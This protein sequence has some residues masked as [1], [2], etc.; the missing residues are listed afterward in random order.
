MAL[1]YPFTSHQ[2]FPAQMRGNFADTPIGRGPLRTGVPSDALSCP[3]LP[4]SGLTVEQE[5]SKLLAMANMYNIDL[6]DLLRLVHPSGSPGTK[7]EGQQKDSLLGQSAPLHEVHA[8]MEVVD[9]R[10]WNTPPNMLPENSWRKSP[11]VNTPVTSPSSVFVPTYTATPVSTHGH[12]NISGEAVVGSET[13]M[14]NEPIDSDRIS[15]WSRR[16]S[17]HATFANSSSNSHAGNARSRTS[18]GDRREPWSRQQAPR[19]GTKYNQDGENKAT[20]AV[21]D[22]LEE[23]RKEVFLRH[24][25]HISSKATSPCALANT[26]HHAE[27]MRINGGFGGYGTFTPAARRNVGQNQS[28]G[29]HQNVGDG[30]NNDIWV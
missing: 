26:N 23:G 3:S 21:V 14:W 27:Q 17:P 22:K 30:F 13:V 24:G 29:W 11:F 20:F 28:D 4:T 5:A 10:F 15:A 25:T 18:T 12:R 6:A 9:E 1:S 7:V 8:R 2:Q 19:V 16:E